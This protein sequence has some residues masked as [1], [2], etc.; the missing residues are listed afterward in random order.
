M[1]SQET[2]VILPD[3]VTRGRVKWFNN[4]AG[5]GFI[6]VSSGEHKNE[7]VFVHHSV[8]KVN[9]D[10]YRYLVQGE[11]VDF[12]L[13]PVSNDCHKWQGDD[14]RG[15]D[16]DK[17]M[18]ESRLEYRVAHTNNKGVSS[19]TTRGRPTYR[20]IQEHSRG[21]KSMNDASPHRASRPQYRQ[22]TPMVARTTYDGEP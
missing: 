13:C 6:T 17:L 21:N 9:K 12:K 4:R 7:D 5:Y 22:H 1:V 11:Y 16:G 14:V 8:I 15:I 2:S 18:C 19:D 3:T 10:Q 20:D